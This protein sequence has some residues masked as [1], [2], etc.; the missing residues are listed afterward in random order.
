MSGHQVKNPGDC[1][2]CPAP[3]VGVARVGVGQEGA[4]GEMM[5]LVVSVP[6]C[7]PCYLDLKGKERK[8]ELL[9]DLVEV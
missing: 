7:E 5:I 3:A 4:N 6:L 8:P 9:R 2:L 1:A